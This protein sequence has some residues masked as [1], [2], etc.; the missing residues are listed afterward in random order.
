MDTYALRVSDAGEFVRISREDFEAAREERRRVRRLLHEEILFDQLATNTTDWLEA[1]VRTAA[2]YDASYLNWRETAPEDR[3][4]LRIA[5][6]LSA[7]MSLTENVEKDKRHARHK[8]GTL[9]CTIARELRNRLQ[10]GMVNDQPVA[11]F[12]NLHVAAPQKPAMPV[13]SKQHG[14]ELRAP[15][16]DVRDD[17]AA[18]NKKRS[19]QFQRACEQEFP[20]RDD[21]DV[22]VV[23]NGH[24][25][26]LS[27]LMN[28][29]RK[30]TGRLDRLVETHKLLIE[31]AK[32]LNSFLVRAVSSGGI[33]FYL[34]ET[35]GMV[36]EVEK[37]RHR[38]ER[39]PV[40]ELIQFGRGSRLREI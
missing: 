22:V 21:L 27:G 20:D 8:C 28:E 24:L 11:G 19:E 10:H 1:M 32:P 4:T 6:V 37:L 3:V 34:S 15:W 23:V 38:N 14:V 16:R 36:K 9:M 29:E 7:A 17:I 2:R 35:T 25:R 13:N 31:R 30:N 26:C 18:I 33:G 40:L 39:L 5:N 12:T